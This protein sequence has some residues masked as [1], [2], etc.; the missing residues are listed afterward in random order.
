MQTK[1]FSACH[2]DLHQNLLILPTLSIKKPE[3]SNRDL[4][5]KMTRGN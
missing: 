3:R 2:L 5:I 1:L 4:S